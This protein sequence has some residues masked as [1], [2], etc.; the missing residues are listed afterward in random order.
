YGAPTT[1]TFAYGTNTTYGNTNVFENIGN[2]TVSDVLS[3]LSVNTA[4]HFMIIASNA[5][6]TIFTGDYVFHTLD[7]VQGVWNLLE[8]FQAGSDGFVLGGVPPG[9][10]WSA[11]TTVPWLHLGAYTNGVGSGNVVFTFDQN[12][13]AT[14]TGEILFGD[15]AVTVT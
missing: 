8:S 5:N 7:Y 2:G 11:S 14:R 10:T 9:I 12:P 15:R 1:V 4:Y 3:N 6:G 13:G